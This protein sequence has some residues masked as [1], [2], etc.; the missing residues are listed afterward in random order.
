MKLTKSRIKEIIRQ[1]L[2]EISGTMGATK[3]LQN[4]AKADAD[5]K[6]TRSSK[7]TQFK[8][9]RAKTA[10]Y[11]TKQSAYDT[12]S[13][14]YDTALA[15]FNTKH[16][17]YRTKNTARTNLDSQ[18]YVKSHKGTLLYR[19]TAA[20]GYSL[21]PAWT[22]ANNELTTAT[23]QRS[24][25]LSSKNT[26]SSEKDS[27][28]SEKDSALSSKNTSRDAYN[29]LV[30]DLNAAKRRALSKK[31]DTSF[32]VS[33]GGGGRGSGKGGTAKGGEGESGKKDES[34]FRILGRDLIKELKDIK[35][36]N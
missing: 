12:K 21:N 23:S 16:S 25:A 17:T 33:A 15:D 30:G 9:W 14:A 8:D 10:T 2:K 32:A 24:S 35:K 13:T 1:E 5:V 6:T 27:A 19:T 18:K 20:R 7:D 26:A 11:N 3:A 31:Q 4:I 29:T 28:E 34:L 22:A 36:Y